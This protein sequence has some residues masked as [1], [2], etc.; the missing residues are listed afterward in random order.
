MIH[1]DNII[2][3]LQ[4]S[5]GISLY[6]SELVKHFQ[7][8]DN[9]VFHQPISSVSIYTKDI[10][11]KPNQVIRGFLPDKITRYLP[12][13]KGLRRG[14][15]L[16]SSYY[17]WAFYPGVKNIVTVYDFTYEF[18]RTGLAQKAHS[19]Q[20]RAALHQADLAIC[21]SEN[22]KQDLLRLYPDISEERVKVVYVAADESFRKISTEESNRIFQRRAWNFGNYL[23]FIG[24]RGHYKNFK[25][26]SE[27]AAQFPEFDFVVAG[28][29]EFSDGEK[30]LL[31]KL[32]LSHRTT[33]LKLP[34]T[35]ELNALYNRAH[36]LLYPSSYEGFG[37]PILEALKAGCPA[38]A[39]RTSSIPEVYGPHGLLAD[40]LSLPIFTSQITALKAQAYRAELL[41]KVNSH[42]QQFSWDRCAKETWDLYQGLMNN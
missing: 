3:G 18:Y 23:L 34:T 17:R 40:D 42:I 33:F 9:V 10:H 38:L 13:N 19:T 16:H 1:L 41:S 39:L 26:A 35:E 28:G 7:Q 27:V 29:A 2:F 24:A 21:I 25:F 11:Y 14:D 20:K 15:L 36:C 31:E 6:W 32:G 4:N 37:I 5:G 8:R 30:Q 22:T 12:I